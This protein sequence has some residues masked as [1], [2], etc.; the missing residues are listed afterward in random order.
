MLER[1]YD[2][3]VYLSLSSSSYLMLFYD[4]AEVSTHFYNNLSALF[5]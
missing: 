3:P 4:P 2:F 1:E 5:A